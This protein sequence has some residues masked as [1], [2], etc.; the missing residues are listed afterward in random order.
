M[1]HEQYDVVIANIVADVLVFIAADLK[2]LLKPGGILI[3]SGIMDKYEDKIAKTYGDMKIIERIHQDE[4]VTLAV[5][6]E[7]Q[8]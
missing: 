1:S 4:W 2:K 7:G 3:L 8:N 6:Q 5:I